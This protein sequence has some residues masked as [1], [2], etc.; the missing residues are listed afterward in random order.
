[1]ITYEIKISKLEIDNSNVDYPNTVKSIFF[2]CTGIDNETGKSYIQKS[3][4]LAP[5]KD[6]S[7]FVPF[8]QLTESIVLEWI[9]NSTVLQNIK[10][11]ISRIIDKMN[12]PIEITDNL[13]WNN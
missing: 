12:K 6:S 3:R 8:E 9:N 7:D 5:D 2:D 4:C 13:P 1:M 10:N 11:N